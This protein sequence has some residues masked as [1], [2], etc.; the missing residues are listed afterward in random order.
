M[1]CARC[2]DA[3]GR[4]PRAR[5]ASMEIAGLMSRAFA[6]LVAIGRVVK[7]QGRHGE[8]RGRAA[9]PTGPTASPA[10]PRVRA[11]PDGA[12]REVEVDGLLAAQGPLRAEARGRRLHRRGRAAARAGAAHRARRS[13]APLP[14]GSYY[15][16]QLR[17]LHVEDRGRAAAGRGGGHPGDGG[18]GAGA[19]GRAGPRGEMLDPAGRRVRARGGPRARARWWRPRPEAGGRCSAIDV[20]TIFPRMVE[21]PAR[22]RHRAARARQAGCVRPARARPARLHRRPAPH[23]GRRARSAAGRAW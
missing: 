19:G 22:R 7:P 2:C 23:G 12:A 20:V 17:G 10:A 9:S 11:R 3:V 18:D 15:H 21:A 14:A 6:D 13:C 5:P 16:H 1:R 4:P 8:V